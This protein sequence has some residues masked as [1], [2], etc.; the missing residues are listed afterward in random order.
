MLH[1]VNTISTLRIDRTRC[2]GGILIFYRHSTCENRESRN[3]HYY[4][5][6]NWTVDTCRR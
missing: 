2:F 3:E 1:E 6:S 5:I 4:I